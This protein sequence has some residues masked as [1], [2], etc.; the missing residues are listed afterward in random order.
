M[1]WGCFGCDAVA[2]KGCAPVL[3]WL[4]WLEFGCNS[5]TYDSTMCQSLK[6]MNSANS[7]SCDFSELENSEIS[8]ST[9]CQSLKYMDS[10]NSQSWK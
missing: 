5:E 7:Q 4:F 8:A 2:M 6:Y 1:I 10:A 3:I 9:I